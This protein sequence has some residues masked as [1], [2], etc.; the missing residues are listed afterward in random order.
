MK[1]RRRLANYFEATSDEDIFNY[2]PPQKTNQIFTPKKVVRKMVD[3]LEEENPGCFDDPDKTFADLYMKSGQYITEIVKCLY[4]SEGMRRAFLMTKSD[5]AMFS[6]I[7]SMDLHRRSVSIALLCVIFWASMTRFIL[8]KMNIICVSLIV[9]RLQKRVRWKHSW[10]V[11]L[12]C[13]P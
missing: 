2:I 10:I 3:L 13:K 4:N 9:F 8:Q 6:S 7:R 11:C 1:L 5:C 12:S